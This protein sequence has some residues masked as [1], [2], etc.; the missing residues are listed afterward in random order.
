MNSDR[1][2]T[3]IFSAWDAHVEELGAA[4][5]YNN[6]LWPV[7]NPRIFGLSPEVAW[8]SDYSQVIDYLKSYARQRRQWLDAQIETW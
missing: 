4:I 8:L 5:A 1:T 2:A 7:A 6:A 3:T